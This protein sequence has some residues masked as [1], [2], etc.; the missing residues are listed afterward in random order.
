MAFSTEE[1]VAEL[2][3][4]RTAVRRLIE[5]AQA[6]AIDPAFASNALKIGLNEIADHEYFDVPDGDR[7]RF[8]TFAETS[9]RG[10]FA[11]L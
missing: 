10:L 3:A 11:G 8:R 4:L 6:G 1:A 7:A 9:Y 2:S 5:A